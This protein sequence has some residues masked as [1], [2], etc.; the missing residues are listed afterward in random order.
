M[1]NEIQIEL[2]RDS[3]PQQMADL[4]LG[5]LQEPVPVPFSFETIGWTI[6]AVIICLLAIWFLL[7]QIRNFRK[8]KYRRD[9]LNDLK[10]VKSGSKELAYSFVILKRTAITAYTRGK[11]GNLT[12][13][14]WLLFLD[15]TAKDIE[16]AQYEKEIE[17]LLYKNIV[18]D[19]VVRKAVLLNIENWIQNHVAS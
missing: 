7:A 14:S 2:S 16:L 18:P 17:N 1:N 19:D 10:N 5:V 15:E 12:G 3:I 4:K 9:A 13:K 6:L 11:V 8:N